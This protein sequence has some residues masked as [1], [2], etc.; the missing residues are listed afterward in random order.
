MLCQSLTSC[1]RSHHGTCSEL[2]IWSLSSMG[3]VTWRNLISF[4]NISSHIEHWTNRRNLMGG[5]NIFWSLD[6]WGLRCEAKGGH[7]CGRGFFLGP[8]F[9]LFAW[10]SVTHHSVFLDPSSKIGSHPHFLVKRCLLYTLTC[11]VTRLHRTPTPLFLFSAALST[12]FIVFKC[13]LTGAGFHGSSW[14]FSSN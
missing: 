1:N 3:N 7:L 12:N 9:R 8:C 10:H 5:G 4:C 2:L 11:A 6:V 14:S 13:A